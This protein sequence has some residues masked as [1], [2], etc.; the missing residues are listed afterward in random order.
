MD[1]QSK[2]TKVGYA[3]V[4]TDGQNISSQIDSLQKAGCEK[5]FHDI[6]SGSKSDR[7]GLQKALDYLRKGDILVVCKLD[8]LGRS[9]KHLI[10]IMNYLHENE[11]NVSKIHIHQLLLNM[12]H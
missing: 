11:K 5:I 2:Q 1:K 6:I 12:C 9:L 4:S 8:R 3:R 7:D 10:D